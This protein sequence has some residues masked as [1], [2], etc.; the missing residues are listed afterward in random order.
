MNEDVEVAFNAMIIDR[1]IF[2]TRAYD[3]LVQ[4]VIPDDF[5]EPVIVCLSPDQILKFERILISNEC[6]I[7][8]EDHSLFLKLGCCTHYMCEKCANKWF[9]SS[10]KCPFC[11]QDLRNCLKK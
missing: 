4:S 7:C 3:Y 9:S 11:V 1:N 2:E 8:N 6:D 5:W 10:V